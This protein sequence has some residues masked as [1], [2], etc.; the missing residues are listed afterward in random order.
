VNAVA[1]VETL[2]KAI[3]YMEKHLLDD[4]TVDRIAKQANISPFHFQRAFSLLTGITVGEYL[5]RRRLTL[6]AQELSGTNA[7][8]IDI[9]LKYGYE[10][11]EAFSKAFRRL[12]GITPSEARN[13][14]GTLVSYNRL[15]IQMR[16]K[17]AEPMEY[18]I[19]QSD[20]FQIVG[21][22]R[23][24]SY[25]NEEQMAEIP[26]FWTEVNR[27]GTADR[28]VR[29]NNGQ[30]KGLLG[31]CVVCN[32]EKTMDYW[33][34][35]QY[36]GDAPEGFSTLEIP[37]AKWAVFA[38]NGPMPHAM[39]NAW[40]RIFSEWL[41]SSGYEIAGTP[42]MEVYPAGDPYSPEYRSEI[43]IPVK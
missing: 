6:A 31:V 19:V 32:E 40:K 21:I 13:H 4:L 20:R 7:K 22:K 16:L 39:Q 17:G 35:T 1:W 26:R 42:E 15:V 33:I 38:V 41:P 11:P 25:A 9:A 2:Q 27:D 37:A 5:R 18:K 28:L 24:Y 8:V 43:W 14:S 10:T 12:H 23:R 30:L 34:A 3:D 36:D 29:L